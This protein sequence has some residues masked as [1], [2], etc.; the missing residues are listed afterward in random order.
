MKTEIFAQAILN[1]FRLCFLY[2]NKNITMDPYLIA[3][4]RNGKKVVFGRINRTNE[5]R[6]FEYDKIFN[7]K[8]IDHSQFSPIIPIL[9]RIN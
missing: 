8:T 1:R 6:Q 4:N 7:I 3:H 5:I 9:P 2:E